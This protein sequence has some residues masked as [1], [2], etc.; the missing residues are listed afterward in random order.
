MACICETCG[1]LVGAQ[2]ELR[3]R[4]VLRKLAITLVVYFLCS[5]KV[6]GLNQGAHGTVWR[7]AK[8]GTSSFETSVEG[9]FGETALAVVWNWA[10]QDDRVN[11]CLRVILFSI[12]IGDILMAPFPLLV[13]VIVY[14][15]IDKICFAWTAYW[16]RTRCAHQLRRI[17]CSLYE[18]IRLHLF[19]LI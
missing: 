11:I 10:S 5:D 13:M 14:S 12:L 19:L 16:W 15:S 3:S 9:K 6:Q 1:L 18:Q 17:W 4:P 8:T 7:A 2:R